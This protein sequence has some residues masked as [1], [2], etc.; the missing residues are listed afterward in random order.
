MFKLKNIVWLYDVMLD[1]GEDHGEIRSI[2]ICLAQFKEALQEN[3]SEYPKF[4][5]RN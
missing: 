1:F 2:N 4:V 3:F 5:S